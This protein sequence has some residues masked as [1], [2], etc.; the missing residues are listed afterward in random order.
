[1]AELPA[2]ILAVAGEMLIPAGTLAKVMATVP[3]PVMPSWKVCPGGIPCSM[4]SGAPDVPP[5][6]VIANVGGLTR[7][8]L[9]I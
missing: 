1:M 9:C 7:K 5:V 4:L 2:T 8:K 3:V 6:C